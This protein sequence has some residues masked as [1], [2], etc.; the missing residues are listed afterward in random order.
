M[1]QTEWAGR[2]QPLTRLYLGLLSFGG[3]FGLP[4]PSLKAGKPV[5]KSP[6]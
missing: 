6:I 3:P 2:D 4:S 5:S 1:S